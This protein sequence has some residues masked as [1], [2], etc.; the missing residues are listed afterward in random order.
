VVGTEENVQPPT[1]RAA[2]TSVGLLLVALIAVVGLANP[3]IAIATTWLPGPLLPG[4]DGTHMVLLALTLV[5][6]TLTAVPGRAD[7][8]QG[9]VHL[10]LLGAFLFLAA[11][12]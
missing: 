3:A 11:S 10:G 12:P 5:V 6:G 8:L 7:V 4:L 1:G 2:L 9:G